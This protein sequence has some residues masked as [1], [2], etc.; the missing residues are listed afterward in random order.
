MLKPHLLL[1]PYKPSEADP[2][3][4][5]K[6]AH[7]LNRAGFGGTQEEIAKIA[8]MGPTRAVD[9]LMDFPDAPAEEQS[10]TD[11]PDLSAIENYPS[12]FRELQKM[13]AGKTDEEKKQIR[14][15][16]MR[17]NSMAISST[18]NWWLNR[19]ARGPY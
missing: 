8:A 4:S 16:L 12:S 9:W 5:V 17:A 3:D 18:V 13:L 19:M 2:F 15:E 7:L 6:A 14:N 10:E 1:Q 11:V